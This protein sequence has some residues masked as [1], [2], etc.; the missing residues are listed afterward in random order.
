M[1]RGHLTRALVELRCKHCSA[2]VHAGWAYH[3]MHINAECNRRLDKP[4]AKRY[5]PFLR[6]QEAPF[7]REQGVI[8]KY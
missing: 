1:R 8:N 3:H 7:F 5:S 4:T 6:R 2:A